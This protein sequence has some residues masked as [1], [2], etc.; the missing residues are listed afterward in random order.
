MAKDS[1]PRKK[2]DRAIWIVPGTI[3]G[4]AVGLLVALWGV[5]TVTSAPLPGGGAQ[6]TASGRVFGLVVRQETG[7]FALVRASVGQH[8]RTYAIGIILLGMLGGCGSAL[9]LRAALR[10]NFGAGDVRRLDDS[11]T[12]PSA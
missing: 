6:V 10:R 5:E 8:M 11:P 7:P 12:E 2:P 9:G 4:G 3:A 1:P